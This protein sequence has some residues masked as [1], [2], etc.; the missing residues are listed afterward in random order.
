M[1]KC[2]VVL[3]SRF[4]Y[5][6]CRQTDRNQLKLVAINQADHITDT[7]FFASLVGFDRCWCNRTHEFYKVVLLQSGIFSSL[8]VLF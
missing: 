8:D 1:K 5:Q 4:C 2:R 6:D 3:N 7:D